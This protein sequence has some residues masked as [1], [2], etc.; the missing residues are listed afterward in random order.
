MGR[1]KHRIV[2]FLCVIGIC[3]CLTGCGDISDIL[4]ITV[5]DIVWEDGQSEEKD[6][7]TEQGQVQTHEP[8]ESVA[9][10][11]QE[12]ITVREDN[13]HENST[14][15]NGAQEDNAAGQDVG[16]LMEE[17]GDYAYNCL[18]EAEQLW[19]RDLEQL[20]DGFGEKCRLNDAGLDAGLTEDNIDKIFQC[21]LYDHPELF[22]V[23]GYS[24]TKYSMAGKLISIDFSGTYTMDRD[25]ALL[26]K[27][28]IE[29]AADE[30]LS[31]VPEDAS[32]YDKVKY[33]YDRIITDTEYDL[34]IPDNQNIYS[35][36]IHHLSVCQGYSKATQYL[37]NRLGME[38]MLVLGTVDTGEGHAWNLVKIDGSYYYLD[39]TWGDA[40]Y[41][42]TDS[43]GDSVD[44]STVNYD[45]LNVT[46]EEILRTHRIAAGI[47]MP[48]CVAAEANY[49]VREG[50]LFT[51]YDREQMEA[52]FAGL[53]DGT[54]SA[55]T[56]KCAS[57]ECYDEIRVALV[58]K[59]EIF[60]FLDELENKV[61]FSQNETQ[62]SLTFW[63]TNE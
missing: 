9:E 3:I 46:T 29:A 6:I 49:Y 4:N 52:L 43:G 23:E 35:V 58:E 45:Y 7:I 37:L 8:A 26:R 22:F 47:P 1:N 36:F 18:N 28:E 44:M 39:T 24:Y 2:W 31:G 50:A 12:S 57:R 40:S 25:T 51:G 13:A 16:F 63:V 17:A 11:F 15:E 55:V 62:L 10:G 38:C 19:Y 56:I 27:K 60:R 54:K 33:V 61:T 53:T 41:R 34:G 59:Q 42:M 48:E 20:F 5:K 30:I 21:V 32:E 14:Q